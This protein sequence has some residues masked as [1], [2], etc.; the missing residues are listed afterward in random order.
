MK[1]VYTTAFVIMRAQPLHA[2]HIRLIEHA[3]TLAADVV[4]LVG[5]AN[6]PRSIRNPWTYEERVAMIQAHGVRVAP[7]ND[8]YYND[9]AWLAGVYEVMDKM[10]DDQVAT[11]NRV[12]VGHSK[13]DTR[14]LQW[15]TAIDFE[16]VEALDEQRSGTQIRELLLSGEAQ[17]SPY[18]PLAPEVL[19]DYAYFKQE[20]ALFAGYPYKETL[21]FN[22]GDAVTMCDGNVLLIQRAKA[23]GRGTWA[24]PG[25]F[26]NADETFQD[27]AIRELYEETNI[28]AARNDLNIID[29]RLFDSPSRGTGNGIPRNTLAVLI[30]VKRDADGNLPAIRAADDAAAARWVPIAEAINDL[31]MYDDHLDILLNMLYD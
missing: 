27:C 22:C 15:Y 6:R 11:R 29:T 30:E 9:A 5:S 10:T 3:K 13:P 14:Y 21:N 2:G 26:K 17:D 31:P 1:Y 7:I 20:A 25:G 18:P 8:N 24:F 16:E 4:V 19:E 23:P 28:D 12:L